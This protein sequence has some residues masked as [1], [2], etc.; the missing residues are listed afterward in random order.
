MAQ[1]PFVVGKLDMDSVEAFDFSAYQGY[2]DTGDQY[3]AGGNTP[4]AKPTDPHELTKVNKRNFGRFHRKVGERT[5]ELQFPSM[6]TLSCNAV[7]AVRLRHTLLM[8]IEQAIVLE[9]VY[10][11]QTEL[12]GKEGRIYFKDQFNFVNYVANGGENFVNFIEEGPANDVEMKLAI[13]EFDRKL[14]SCMNLSDPECFKALICPLGL[15]ELRAVVQYEVMNLQALIVGARTNQILLDNSERKLREIEFFQQTFTV[16][17]PVFNL[18]EKLQGSNLFDSNL[19][20]LPG[21]EKSAVNSYIKSSVAEGYYNI[22]TRKQ[23]VR[24]T[25]ESIFKQVKNASVSLKD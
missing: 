15:E 20:K 5:G 3:A 1:N 25:T 8:T 13:D 9:D 10:N 23:K 14:R 24:D 12:M 11:R 21:A 16:A 17:N 22:I 7:E 2:I 19:K 4:G 6:L 18:F